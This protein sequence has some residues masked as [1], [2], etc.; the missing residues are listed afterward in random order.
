MCTL[1]VTFHMMT[2]THWHQYH[3]VQ[4]FV[5][6]TSVTKITKISTPQKLPAIQY[7]VYTPN[8]LTT[9]RKYALIKKYALNKWVH[10]LTRLNLRYILMTVQSMEDP[11]NIIHPVPTRSKLYKEGT[12]PKSERSFDQSQLVIKL[13][14]G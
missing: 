4:N 1:M 2:F 12:K 6:V 7:L 8:R 10:L 5:T 11:C 3:G 13:Q 9:G 14:N